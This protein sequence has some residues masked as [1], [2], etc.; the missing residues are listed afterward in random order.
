MTSC[1]TIGFFDGVHLGHQYL[2]RQLREVAAARGLSPVA[3]TFA[4]HPRKTLQPGFQPRL[5]TTLDE[6]RGFIGDCGIS[7]CEILAFSPDLAHLT[8]REFMR[9]HLLPLG[10][11]CLL[12]GYDHRFGSDR[13]AFEDCLP[14][15]QELGI[16]IVQAE[17][18]HGAVATVSSSVI[19]SL[20]DEG[21]VTRAT[22]CLGRNYSISGVVVEGYKEGRKLG[23]PTANLLP[24]S[25]EKI[26]PKC[27]SYA[28]WVDF[29]GRRYAAM[30]NIGLR[31]T[32]GNGTETSIESHIFDFDG[33]LY[34]QSVTLRFV[35]RLRDERKY[36][37]AG[38]LQRQLCADAATA[39]QILYKEI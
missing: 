11:G 32:F 6:K 33:D 20:L 21:D 9:N 2:F 34:G 8:A 28:T 39:R 10:V 31:P 12:V 30:T 14:L 38:D 27:G 1:A 5:L 36:P 22:Q 29:G 35:R 7:R 24:D 4:E 16:A 37:A 15:G 17:A 23:F 25:S 26:V 18:Y 19:R 3:V 13:C